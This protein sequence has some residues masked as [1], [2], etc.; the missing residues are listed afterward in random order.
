MRLAYVDTSPVAL[1]YVEEKTGL[2]M[3]VIR[4]NPD[5]YAERPGGA[6]LRSPEGMRGRNR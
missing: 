6:A 5:Y 2:E 1:R 3:E 4:P